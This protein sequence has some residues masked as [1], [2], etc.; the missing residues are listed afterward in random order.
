MNTTTDLF[1]RLGEPARMS[2]L[3]RYGLFHPG[4]KA[5]MEAIAAHSAHQLNA[6]ISLVSMVLDSAQFLLGAHGVTGWIDE[7]LGTPAEWALCTHTVL[8]G[9]PY[10]LIDATTDAVHADNPL[11]D[12]IGV[13]SY[14]GVPLIDDSGHVLGAHCIIDVAPRTFTE[15]DLT[16][17]H[18]GADQAMEIL[19]AYR[20]N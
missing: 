2:Q 11:L 7:A 3:A 13:R 5:R 1:A 18:H 17:L 4:L 14:A 20:T 9:R 10:C 15:D 8:A 16:V 6:P 12:M 19:S